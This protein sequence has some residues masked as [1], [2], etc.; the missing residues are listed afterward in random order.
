MMAE[1]S[2]RDPLRFSTSTSSTM[3]PAKPSPSR[4]R[5]PLQSRPNSSHAAASQLPDEY[6]TPYPG[7]SNSPVNSSASALNDAYHVGRSPRPP[8]SNPAATSEALGR[9]KSMTSAAKRKGRNLSIWSLGGIKAP[10]ADLDDLE[11]NPSLS[12]SSTTLTSSQKAPTPRSSWLAKPPLPPHPSSSSSSFIRAQKHS[13]LSCLA[14]VSPPSP[15]L[16]AHPAWSHSPSSSV[17]PSSH[18]DGHRRST[19]TTFSTSLPAH[20]ARIPRTSASSDEKPQLIIR[21]KP[22]F[23]ET[24]FKALSSLVRTASS[25]GTDDPGKEEG[26]GAGRVEPLSDE[27]LR[28]WRKGW[29]GSASAASLA[30]GLGGSGKEL[31][32]GTGEMEVLDA[33]ASTQS[34]TRTR[35]RTTSDQALGE[36]GKALEGGEEDDEVLVIDKTK[37]REFST[38][39]G[40]TYASFVPSTSSPAVSPVPAAAPEPSSS[41]ALVD[42]T[43]PPTPSTYPETNLNV[44]DFVSLDAGLSPSSRPPPRFPTT[45]SAS[46]TPRNS[47]RPPSV[48]SFSGLSLGSEEEMVLSSIAVEG[49]AEEGEK[50]TYSPERVIPSAR[51]SSLSTVPLPVAI[52]S[53]I[54]VFSAHASSSTFSTALS[55]SS[56]PPRP[57]RAP[58]RPRPTSLTAGQAQAWSAVPLSP[59]PRPPPGTTTTTPFPSRPSRSSLRR[60][61]TAPGPSI[62]TARAEKPSTVGQEKGGKEGKKSSWTPPPSPPASDPDERVRTTAGLGIV[63]V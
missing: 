56:S 8:I 29:N 31:G 50:R 48:R 38:L 54:P 18:H 23:S 11:P 16:E 44:L 30:T 19:S 15:T 43:A 3:N 12:S 41:S 32:Q 47:P 28:S 63:Q 27:E 46:T 33:L 13:A 35:T 57:P 45:N 7:S 17:S 34:R 21:K 51:S 36:G 6:Y 58:S 1:S 10:D 40:G 25:H 52:P 24:A 55:S 61:S 4:W 39:L 60:P 22:S 59:P 53:G 2:S 20:S 26:E 49:P 14:P 5:R 62:A 42:T 9:K 37:S